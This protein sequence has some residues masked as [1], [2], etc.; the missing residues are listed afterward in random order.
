MSGLET[1]G[2]IA[3]GAL[4][5]TYGALLGLGGGI[6]VVPVLLFAQVAPREAAGTAMVMILANGLSGSISYFRQRLVVVRTAL[7]FSVATLP[8]AFAGAYLDQIVSW[9]WFHLLFALIL[10]VVGVRI[11]ANPTTA[12]AKETSLHE[13][14]RLS[15]PIALAIGLVVGIIASAFGIGGGV[16]FVPVMVYVFGFQPLIAVAT[17]TFII[18]ITSVFGVA[19]HAYYHDILWWPALAI[20]VGAVAGAQIGSR[21]A[22]KL[23]QENL[24]RLF[25]LALFLTAGYLVYTA[26]K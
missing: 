9:L 14:S 20:S 18:A 10:I 11:F 24:L 12:P 5:G 16:I 22:P 19:A 13:N 17:S 7:M 26:F 21:L 6:L 23:R 8:G 25:S 1:A 2:F 4:A 3:L 15:L